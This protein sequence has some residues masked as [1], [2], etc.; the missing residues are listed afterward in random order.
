MI[1]RIIITIK[2]HKT[3]TSFQVCKAHPIVGVWGANPV[4]IIITHVGVWG[5][6]PVP[7][8]ITHVR[9]W[10]ANPIKIFPVTIQIMITPPYGRGIIT[11]ESSVVK[12]N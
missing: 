7:I 12:W 11:N 5:A 9:V 3:K 10:G 4:P 8:I 6:N 2:F 1:N